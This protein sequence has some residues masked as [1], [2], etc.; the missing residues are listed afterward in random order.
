[1]TDWNGVL[2]VDKPAGPTSH[3]IVARA[4][5]ALQTRRIGHTG[6]LDPFASGL[7]LL[8]LG[9]ATRLAEYLTDLPKTYRATL[10]LGVQTNTDDREGEPVSQSEAWSSLSR[11]DVEGALL[12]QVGERMQVPPAFS[13]KRVAGERMYDKARRGEEVDLPPVPVTI[14]SLDVTRFAPPEV[15]FDVTVSSGTYIR[16]IARDAGEQLGVGAHLAQLRRSAIG[17]WSVDR[18]V[19]GAEIDAD[20]ARARLIPPAQAVGHLARVTVSAGEKAAIGYGQRL[21]NRGGREGVI[22]LIDEEGDLV[23]IAEASGEVIQ[24]RKVFL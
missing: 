23:A 6:T 3:D 10:R 22:A 12:T 1:M 7:L 9:T 19:D 18:A 5:R 15:D 17:E 4:R 24:P 8:C 21:E 14:H 11:Q 16:A 2:P 20:L 13:A